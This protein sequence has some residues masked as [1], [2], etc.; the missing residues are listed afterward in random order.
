MG[1]STAARRRSSTALAIAAITGIIAIPTPAAADSWSIVPVDGGYQVTLRLDDPLPV[2]DAAPELAVNGQSLGYATESD[3]GH[4]LTLLTSDPRAGEAG[5]VQVA[6][7]GV[8]ESGAGIAARAIFTPPPIPQ[9]TT[10]ATD[11]GAPGPYHVE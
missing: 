3:E 2:R 4:T 11:P 5:S 8:V 6:W 9:P 1:L 10:I 7:N